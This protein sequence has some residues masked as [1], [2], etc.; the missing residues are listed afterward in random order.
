MMTAL[1][2]FSNSRIVAGTASRSRRAGAR[3]L[4]ERFAF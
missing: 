1:I 3:V 2:Q 4:P